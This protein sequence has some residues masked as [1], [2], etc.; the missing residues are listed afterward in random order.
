MDPSKL[1]AHRRRQSGQSPS[2][3]RKPLINHVN[4]VLSGFGLKIVKKRDD[5]IVLARAYDE[6]MTHMLRLGVI[7]QETVEHNG[8]LA[9]L[10]IVHAA[11][12]IEEAE[13]FIESMTRNEATRDAAFRARNYIR[14]QPVRRNEEDWGIC[15]VVVNWWRGGRDGQ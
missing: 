7:V 3:Y 4:R 8:K 11:K 10:K 1:H 15:D 5:P 12:R 6:A 14:P 2:K 13:E 9:D